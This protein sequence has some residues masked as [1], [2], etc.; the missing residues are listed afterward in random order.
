MWCSYVFTVLELIQ[1]ECQRSS[2]VMATKDD[3][4]I[5]SFL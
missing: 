1:G 4:L 3:I 5:P 2:G